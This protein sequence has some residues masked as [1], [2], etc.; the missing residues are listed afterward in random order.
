MSSRLDSESGLVGKTLVV[1]LIVIA[2]VG[3]VALDGGAIVVTKLGVSD[4][5]QQASFDGA[6]RYKATGDIR[7]AESAANATASG[8]GAKLVRFVLN[9]S[10]GAVTVTLTKK[11]PTI[12]VQ[13]LS[14]TKKWGQIKVTDTS[15]APP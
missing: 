6:E 4:A 11:A 1:L 8:Q 9:K 7:E 14:F 10:T 15:A 2:V 13:R 12:F 5:A 3:V